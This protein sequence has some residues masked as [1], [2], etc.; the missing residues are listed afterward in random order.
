M[1]QL[2][3]AHPVLTT[4]PLPR[5]I[6]SRLRSQ[7]APELSPVWTRM[8]RISLGL[9]LVSIVACYDSAVHHQPHLSLRCF[10]LH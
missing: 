1:S 2:L 9:G 4:V 6:I 10:G 7:L 8:D 3:V 5:L